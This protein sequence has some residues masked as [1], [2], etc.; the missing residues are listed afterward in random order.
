MS[1]LKT[2]LRIGGVAIVMLGLMLLPARN[3]VFDKGDLSA[4]H[5]V[6]E[7]GAFTWV[8]FCLIFVGLVAF[9]LSFVVRGELSD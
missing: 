3:Y 2:I 6:R 8:G 9:A 7:L 5:D 1:N 4:F